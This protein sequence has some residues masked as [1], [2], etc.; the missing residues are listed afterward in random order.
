MIVR[1]F[2]KFDS[3]KLVTSVPLWAEKHI[4][5]LAQQLRGRETGLVELD[6]D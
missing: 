4:S 2:W 3:P 6:S 1:S 5:S